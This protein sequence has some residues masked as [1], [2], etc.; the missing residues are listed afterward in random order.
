MKFDSNRAWQDSVAAVRANREVLFPVAGVFFLLPSL[1]SGVLLADVQAH[2]LENIENEAALSQ[3]VTGNFGLLLGVG[4]G[5]MAGAGDGL[6]RRDGGCLPTV[7]ARPWARHLASALR[8]LPTLIGGRAACRFWLAG[9]AAL[10]LEALWRR[11][12]GMI[13]GVGPALAIGHGRCW[14]WR[15]WWLR[16]G[17]DLAGGAGCG[18]SRG[19]GNPVRGAGAL[20]AADP[21]QSACV[22]SAFSAA[23]DCLHRHRNGEHDR[24]GRPRLCC[25]R[26][27]DMPTMYRRGGVRRDQR[28]GQRDPHRGAGSCA[29]AARWSRPERN[30]ADFRMK[31]LAPGGWRLLS[32]K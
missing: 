1:L 20:M 4:I 18:R 23:G 14:W 8:A 17:Q 30:R 22:C 13:P 7:A 16:C 19:C 25:W 15:P 29:P 32:E 2:M 26:G 28:G 11:A 12:L 5:G 24:A 27:R 9:Y 10:A 6:S 31:R 3:L 21:R